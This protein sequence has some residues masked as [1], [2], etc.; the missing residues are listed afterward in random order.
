MVGHVSPNLSH[1]VSVAAHNNVN[2]N[3]QGTG[4]RLVL[5]CQGFM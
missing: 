2:N 4:N 5:Q 3:K 1:M